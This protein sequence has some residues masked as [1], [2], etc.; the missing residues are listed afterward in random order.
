MFCHCIGMTCLHG[1]IASHREFQTFL[2]IFQSRY[3]LCR[4]FYRTICSEIE[5]SREFSSMGKSLQQLAY[6]I[7]HFSNG[8]LALDV[9]DFGFLIGI[10]TDFYGV[11]YPLWFSRGRNLGL[12][13]KCPSQFSIYPLSKQPSIFRRFLLLILMKNLFS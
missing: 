10:S 11:I 12:F 13:R 4:R 7:S 2:V 8:F 5:H 3:G 9:R 6:E 1:I